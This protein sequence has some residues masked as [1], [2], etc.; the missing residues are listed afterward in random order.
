ML[1]IPAID[2]LGENVVRLYQGDYKKSRVFGNDPAAFARQFSEAG[3]EWLHIVD[4]DGAREGIPRNLEAVKKIIE[5]AP[6]VKI[7]LGG[8]LRDEEAVRRCFELGVERVI[9]GTAALRD[10]DFA[11]RMTVE[12]GERLAVGVD[13]RRGRVSVEGWLSDT[14]VDS[15]AF[16]GEMRDIGVAHIIYTDISKDGVGTGT[17]LSVYRR[18]SKEVEGIFFTAAGGISSLSDIKALGD[19]GVYAAILGSALYTGAVTLKEAIET[20]LNS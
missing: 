2:L 3:A 20:A 19:I 13:A 7:E 9:L 6:S 5:A 14:D 10:R 15:V 11:K 12:F 16:C 4:L 18:L 17:N 1:V 8:G